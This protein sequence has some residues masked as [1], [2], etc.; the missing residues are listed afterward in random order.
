MP[1]IDWARAAE[2]LDQAADI[3]QA[4]P[5]LDPDGAIRVV[6]FGNSDAHV[7]D[8]G[9]PVSDLYDTA[10]SAITGGHY[11]KHGFLD[12]LPLQEVPTADA[13]PVACVRHRR[14]RRRSIRRARRGGSSDRQV[15][16]R[17]PAAPPGT[18]VG[19]H[20]QHLADLRFHV[21]ARHRTTAASRAAR[22]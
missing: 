16:V 19:R 10:Y 22:W 9:S 8:D 12:P 7:P 5:G 17:V 21:A 13:I 6:L 11:E 14:Q 4:T 18:S 20:A 3:M 1:T 2:V 15:C